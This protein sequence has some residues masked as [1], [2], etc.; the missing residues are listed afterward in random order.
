MKKIKASLNLQNKNRFCSWLKVL[1]IILTFHGLAQGK[2]EF[3]ELISLNTNNEP[4]A[5]VL[6]NVSHASGY[7]F[8][9]DESW[10]DLPITVKFDAIPLEQALKRILANLN[11]AIIYQSDRKVLIRI[12]DK[13]SSFS[14]PTDNS[15]INRMPPEPAYQPPPIE[16]S[17]SPNP[18]PPEPI[19]K[20]P[21]SEELESEEPESGSQEPDS[22]EEKSKDEDQ[23]ESSGSETENRN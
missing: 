22:P 13:D 1:F 23:E 8:I 19:N 17:T 20:E 3:S 16:M 10:D 6:T 12:Y 14:K 18:V 9:I 2:S 7:E 4:L 11:H 15:A 21:D 5:E